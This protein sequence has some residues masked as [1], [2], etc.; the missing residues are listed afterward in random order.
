M[1]IFTKNTAAD[2]SAAVFLSIRA[3]T[4]LLYRRDHR[5]NMAVDNDEFTELNMKLVCIGKYGMAKTG[6]A[7]AWFLR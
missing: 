5:F 6:V 7:V 2:K 1:R 4:I 3:Q